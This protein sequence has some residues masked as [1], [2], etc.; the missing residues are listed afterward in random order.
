MI[1]HHPDESLLLEYSAGNLDAAHALCLRLHLNAC[2]RCRCQ[3]DM[4]DSVGAMLLQEE[5]GSH[6]SDDLFDRILT[7]ID[8]LPQ[9][10]PPRPSAMDPLHKLVGDL[11]ALPWKR[12][13]VDVSVYD[14]SA[15]FPEQRD[16]V[17]LQRI[18][19]GGKAPV[20]THR[21]TETTV[22]VQGGFTDNRG[23]FEEGDFVILDQHD[24]HKPIALH[25]EDC[26]TLS[27]LSAPVRLTGP[28]ARLLNPF[29]R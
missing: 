7:R 16:R 12:Q 15:F 20:H 17:V 5:P 26:I 13:I 25:G 19:A 8:T 14:L 1:Q 18:S 6:L 3:A 10:A 21:G 23:V 11:N 2:S 27:I 24:I 9:E 28:F 4:L 22:V 29:I